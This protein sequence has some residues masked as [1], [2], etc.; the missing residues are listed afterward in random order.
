MRARL[1]KVRQTLRYS[2]WF[3]PSVLTLAAAGVSLALSWLDGRV[4]S[5]L[6]ARL[7]PLDTASMRDLL[8][9]VAGAM[10]TVATTAF[11]IVI[12]A[13]QLASGQLGPRLLRNFVRDRGNQLAF[14]VF[15]G[16][17]L[18]CLLLL[19][20]MGGPDGPGGGPPHIALLGALVLTAVGVGVLI[21]FIHHAALSVQKDRVIAGVSAE[22]MRSL[23]KLYPKSIGAEPPVL[24]TDAEGG[25]RQRIP[26]EA[27]R[28]WDDAVEVRLE[29]SGYVQAV[30]ARKLMDVAQR[31]DLRVYVTKRP[32]D[33]VGTGTVAA[34]VRPNAALGPAVYRRLQD[35]FVLGNERTQQQD[36][37]F[38]FDQLVEIAVRALSPGINDPFT[39]M[40]CIDRLADALGVVA[41]TAFPS[42]Y[43]FDA[44]GKLRVVT[45]PLNFEVL[46]SLVLYPVAEAA[47]G[48]ADVLLRLLSAGAEVADSCEDE[49][50]Q[51]AL[52]AFVDYVQD[53]AV[54]VPGAAARGEEFRHAHQRVKSRLKRPLGVAEGA[55]GK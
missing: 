28:R 22:L 4:D 24:D 40:R 12:V 7:V 53:L 52:G 50:E 55:K 14:G 19:R 31:H 18:Y 47:A 36:V 15:L 3:L 25:R 45:H 16:T 8:G 2:F 44:D 35:V 10:I 51:S 17:F 46:V 43:R 54:E 21:F 23:G 6:A 49:R 32:G 29:G 13:L 34:R 39:A 5:Q 11:S 42:P 33:F 1:G 27:L 41:R 48:R 20:R 37:G 30:D 9:M 26:M 38:V